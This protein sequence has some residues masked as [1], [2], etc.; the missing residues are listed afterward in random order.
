MRRV[1]EFR[2]GGNSPFHELLRVIRGRAILPEQLGQLPP[3]PGFRVLPV[4]EGV[5][6][7]DGEVTLLISAGLG[8]CEIESLRGVVEN[9]VG[10]YEYG[11]PKLD[12]VERVIIYVYRQSPAAYATRLLKDGNIEGNA[13]LVGIFAEMVGG[14]GSSCTGACDEPMLARVHLQPPTHYYDDHC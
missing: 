11:R 6:I 9:L 1:V 2:E 8:C 3:S 7:P 14:G 10:L 12:R 5:A 13:G 4:D